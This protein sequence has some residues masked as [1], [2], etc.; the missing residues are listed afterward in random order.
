MTRGIIIYSQ[1]LISEIQITDI[2]IV[3]KCLFRLP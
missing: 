2:S 1:L 3:N